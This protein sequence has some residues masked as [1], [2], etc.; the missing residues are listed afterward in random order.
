MQFWK[1]YS[2]KITI[3]LQSFSQHFPIGYSINFNEF[4]NTTINLETLPIF[5]DLICYC[6]DSK[7]IAEN[8]DTLNDTIIGVKHA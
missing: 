8:H 4:P 1:N 6:D 7:S 3:I 2:N 5:S